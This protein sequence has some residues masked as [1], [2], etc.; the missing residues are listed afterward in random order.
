MAAAQK[1]DISSFFCQDLIDA[2]AAP[3]LQGLPISGET[4]ELFH[5]LQE[6]LDQIMS[7]CPKK[8]CVFFFYGPGSLVSE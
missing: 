3:K 1:I 2:V 5:S 7:S 8:V 6:L 4:D